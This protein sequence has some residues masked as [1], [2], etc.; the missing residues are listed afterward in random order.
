MFL[1]SSHTKCDKSLRCSRVKVF[2]VIRKYFMAFLF[3]AISMGIQAQELVVKS[4]SRFL[5]LGDSYTIGQSVPEEDRW[6]NQLVTALLYEGVAVDELKIIAQTGWRT[7]NLWS[8]VGGL[9]PNPPYNLVSLLIGVNNQYQGVDIDLYPGEFRQLLNKAIDLCG[10]QK[11]SVFVLSI[12]DYGYTPFG[13]SN[14]EQ[15]SREIDQYNTINKQ[16]SEE[17]GV[18]YFNITDISRQ[19]LE[20]PEY[21]ASDNLHPSGEMYARWVELIMKNIRIDR[22]TSSGLKQAQSDE[23]FVFPNPATAELNFRLPRGAEILEISTS[24]GTQ[25]G[26]WE[27]GST[28]SFRLKVSDWSS[29]VYFYRFITRNNTSA[30]GKFVVR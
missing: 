28:E 14:R 24:N 13:A 16:I 19:A 4:P 20:K 26:R 7:D 8:M 1:V 10:G 25:I 29:G 3:L 11:E 12:P 27:P 15:I 22:T 30:F 5:A 23:P 2:T 18:A 9:A 21:I 6:P 17:I